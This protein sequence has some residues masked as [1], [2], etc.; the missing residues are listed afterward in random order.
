MRSSALSA[1]CLVS[2]TLHFAMASSRE[3]LEFEAEGFSSVVVSENEDT[4][5]FR[6]DVKSEEEF[7]RWKEHYMKANNTCFNVKRVI[8]CS[9]ERLLLHKVFMC[10]H[11]DARNTGKKTTYTRYVRVLYM[12]CIILHVISSIIVNN[13]GFLLQLYFHVCQ[14]QVLSYVILT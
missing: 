10:Q 1:G 14:C 2:H 12:H 3:V 5:H 8:K 9:G 6:L 4:V 11:G 13:L 7:Q